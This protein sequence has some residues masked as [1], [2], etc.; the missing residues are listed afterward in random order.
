MEELQRLST[1]HRYVDEFH[2]EF[3]VPKEYGRSCL[4][5]FLYALYSIRDG[6]VYGYDLANLFSLVDVTL[7]QYKQFTFVLLWALATYGHRDKFKDR[8]AFGA[9]VEKYKS[10]IKA[11][12]YKRD[13]RF[14][15]LFSFLFPELQQKLLQGGS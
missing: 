8:P 6:K 12:E 10:N 9:K 1:N 7:N 14:D 13:V 4:P 5:K 3:G 15:K 11:D 2:E